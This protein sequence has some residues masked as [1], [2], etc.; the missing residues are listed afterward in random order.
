MLT[1]AKLQDKWDKVWYHF[2]KYFAHFYPQ[3]QKEPEN[4]MTC[5]TKQQ[6]DQMVCPS[7]DQS[8]DMNDPQPPGCIKITPSMTE[9]EYFAA[10]H[11][12]LEQR[13]ARRKAD[14][15]INW[16]GPIVQ[17]LQTIYITPDGQQFKEHSEAIKHRLAGI[18][19]SKF[20][21]NPLYS[22]AAGG[23]VSLTKISSWVVDNMSLIHN[24]NDFHEINLQKTNE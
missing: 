8:W 16:Q 14:E 10:L 20:D 21:N 11:E 7:C 6:S 3:K 17:S 9:P 24:I 22:D 13:I 12:P 19:K 18:I 1:D 2:P 5:D 15:S 23:R 4:T